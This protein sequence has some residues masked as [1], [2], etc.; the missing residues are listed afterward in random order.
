M[1]TT[2]KKLQGEGICVCVKDTF[3]FC[4][5]VFMCDP[6]TEVGGDLRGAPEGHRGRELT[7]EQ[8]CLSWGQM[9]AEKGWGRGDT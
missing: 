9:E 7:E 2:V 3:I 6:G 4:W 5:H 1:T 8:V